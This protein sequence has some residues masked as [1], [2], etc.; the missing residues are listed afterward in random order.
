MQHP[1]RQNP[2]IAALALVAVA[3]LWLLFAPT[4]VGGQA[5]YVIISGIS[6]EPGMHRGDL[7]ILRRAEAY[8]V[9]DVVTYRHPTI[10]PIIH[11]IIG[12]DGERFVFQGDNNDFVDSYR[13]RADELIGR[14]WVHLPRAGLAL[15]FLRQPP[16]FAALAA[17]VIGTAT[18]STGSYPIRG[19]RQSRVGTQTSTVSRAAILNSLLTALL[20]LGL[21]ALCLAVV[22]FSRP[23]T[24]VVS[25]DLPYAHEGRFDYSAPAPADLYDRDGAHGGDPIFRK[26]TNTI[27]VSFTY[28][29]AS[30][31][32]ANVRGVARLDAELSDGSGWRRTVALAPAAA[33]SG[34][35]V[36]LAGQLNLDQLQAMVNTFEAQTGVQR[37]G[38][39]VTLLPVVQVSGS[40]ADATLDETFTPRLAFSMDTARLQPISEA[41]NDGLSARQESSLIRERSEPASLSLWLLK[42]DVLTARRL[43]LAG[44]EIA[45]VAGLLTWRWLARELRRDEAMALSMRF[46]VLLVRS[47]EGG[48][49]A[50]GAVKLAALDDLGRLAARLGQPLVVIENGRDAGYYVRDG[51][52]VYCVRR[53]GDRALLPR[54]V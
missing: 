39:I 26:V 53:P 5:T 44:L 23:T 42:L 45:L 30:D 48:A 22:A 3:A 28:T 12:R 17:I 37:G 51:E 50:S 32:P 11:R 43:A 25:A 54:E 29:L 9:G 1:R 49:W 6:M 18:M 20:G 4:P 7:A 36:A 8:A 24:R 27:A 38:Y 19:R 2:V 14:L 52:A 35:A 40:L 33:F 16:I 46:G 13:P 10:G 15:Q 34:S 41:G 31:L 47:G 21:A